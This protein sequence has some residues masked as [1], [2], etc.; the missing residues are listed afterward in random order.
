VTTAGAT[1]AANATTTAAVVTTTV[2]VTTTRPNATTVS[3]TTI[4]ATTKAAPVVT[5]VKVTATVAANFTAVV[6]VTLG[7]GNCTVGESVCVD[8]FTNTSNEALGC[9]KCVS[10]VTCKEGS[11]KL[12]FTVTPAAVTVNNA[13]TQQNPNELLA[14][15]ETKMKDSNSPLGK[16]VLGD[17]VKLASVEVKETVTASPQ[18]TAPP[19]ASSAP[20]A[21]S[22]TVLGAALALAGLMA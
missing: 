15:L 22:V 18:T 6:C 13:V 17:Y 8:T 12:D 4:S 19:S 21:A 16:S 10:G 20:C 3:A 9:N 5:A 11:I 7:K 14:T 2:G 1:T